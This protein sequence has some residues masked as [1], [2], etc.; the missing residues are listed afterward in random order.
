MAETFTAKLGKT[1]AGPRTRFWLEGDR[2]AN[3]GFRHGNKFRR[4]WGEGTLTLTRID[5]REY[6]KIGRAERG[7]VSGA[8]DRPVIDITGA[9]VAKTFA[10]EAVLVEFSDRRISVRLAPCS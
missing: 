7:T 6:D 10:A 4:E 8:N 3:A 5:A 2:M 1:E 9:I